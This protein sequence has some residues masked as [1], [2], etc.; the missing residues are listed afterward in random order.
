M[1][2]FGENWTI[3]PIEL[4]GM[5]S[6]FRNFVINNY[7][8]F[9]KALVFTSDKDYLDSLTFSSECFLF[10]DRIYKLLCNIKAISCHIA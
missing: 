3:K 4:V 8:K 10:P 5:T 6:S 1:H 2:E 7:H 9:L